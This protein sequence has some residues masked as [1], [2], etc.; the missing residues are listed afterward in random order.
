M[1]DG[2]V[3]PKVSVII[4]CYN[5]AAYL[6]D[7]IQSVLDQTYEEFEIIV[8]D[9]GSTDNTPAVAGGFDDPRVRY[10]RQ[11][12]K[13]RS[14][15]RNTGINASR[16]RYVAFLDADD[17]FLPHKLE[18]QVR[19]LDEC[20]A[21][22]LAAGGHAYVDA[23]GT[24]LHEVHPWR[25]HT[26]LGLQAWLLGC[27][28]AI[29]ATLVRREWLERVGGFD[30]TLHRAEDWDLWLRL[31]HAGC[32]RAWV[33]QVVCCY[34]MHSG[35]SVRDGYALRQGV[36]AVLDKFFARPDVPDDIRARRDYI[37]AVA[38][39]RAAGREYSTNQAEHAKRDLECALA[40][41]PDLLG[42]AGEPL[43][44]ELLAWADAPGTVDPG[45]CMKRLFANLPES[46]AALHGFRRKALSRRAMRSFFQAHEVGDRRTVRNS[47]F[48][49]IVN[50]PAWLLNRGVWSIGVEAFLGPRVAGW[51]RRLV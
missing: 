23:A 39:M 24:P 17:L 31:A 16:G 3:Q 7:A 4:A 49:G 32:P 9:D 5:G 51:L 38:H 37:Y 21:V 30:E 19:Y 29:H 8:V 6:A 43:L 28:A 41:A 45:A 25:A 15:A 26:D 40:L 42:E 1:T 27:L 11:E 48:H 46:A 14:N 20:P 33:E 44:T 47:T 2:R 10:I 13:G 35:Q 18:V 22:G 12:N 50:D 34:R 36:F